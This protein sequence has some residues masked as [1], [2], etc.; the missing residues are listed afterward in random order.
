MGAPLWTNLFRFRICVHLCSSVVNSFSTKSSRLSLRSGAAGNRLAAMAADPPTAFLRLFI[1]IA[2][3]PA[4]RQEIARAQGRLRRLSPPG[5]VRW[6]RPDQFHVTLK[7][8]GDVP[9]GQVPALE[10]S[11]APV[12]AAFPALP[13][14]ARGIG[15]FPNARQPRVIWA[16]ASDGPGRLPELHR[17]IAAALRWLAPAEPPEKFTAHI[18]LGRFKPGRHAAIPKLLELTAALRD[19]PFGDWPARAVELVRSELTSTG[20]EHFPLA[21]FPLA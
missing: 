6:T 15:F 20:A 5:A 3:P 12:C 16:A 21:S 8:L 1:A 17:Q 14:S 19:Q 10:T 4:V 7:F 11:L 9:A 13:L 2:V 18:T